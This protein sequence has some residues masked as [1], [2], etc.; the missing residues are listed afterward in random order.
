MEILDIILAVPFLWFGFKGLTNGFFKEL[1][2]TIA[3]FIAI[4]VAI[5]FSDVVGSWLAGMFSSQSKYFK[6]IVLSITFLGALL[7]MKIGVWIA[8][9]FFSTTGLGFINK[10]LGLFFGLLKGL[11]IVGL[12]LFLIQK[13]DA[14]E[15]IISQ[16]SK[17]KS[18]LFKPINTF[19]STAFPSL[20]HFVELQFD[21]KDEK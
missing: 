16:E 7:F 13:F 6:L 15:T 1:F 21:K 20:I 2:S 18:L 17:Q 9:K 12:F 3:L 5:H 19:V 10:I 8:D 14:N 4:Y 11:L